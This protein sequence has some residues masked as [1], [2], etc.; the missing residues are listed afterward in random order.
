ME[1]I[2][3]LSHSDLNFTEKPDGRIVELADF[4]FENSIPQ[5]MTLLSMDQNL[6]RM[7]CVLSIITIDPTTYITLLLSFLLSFLLLLFL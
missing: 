7:V 4:N 6:A 2:L 1:S 3:E 5:V